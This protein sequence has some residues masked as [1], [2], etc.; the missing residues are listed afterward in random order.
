MTN[1]P[2]PP[3]IVYP[4]RVASAAGLPDRLAGVNGNEID[5]TITNHRSLPFRLFDLCGVAWRFLFGVA[6][7][8]VLLAIVANI[9]LL[10]L[11]ALGYLIES[12]GRVVR[13]GKVSAG[14]VGIDKARVFGGILLGVWLI[15]LPMRALSG[16]WQDAWL[17]DPSSPQ[18]RF[19]R[20][21]Q[22]ALV[23]LLLMHIATAT[24]CG[25]KLRHFLW[26]LLAPFLL[27]LRFVRGNRLSRWFLDATI[28]R[29]FP[30]LS[31][32]I[33]HAPPMR[34]WFVP[35]MIWQR[36]RGGSWLEFYRSCRDTTCEFGA[37]L[38]LWHYWW[39][40][41]KAFVGTLI[42][43]VVPTM[44]LASPSGLRPGPAA[45]IGLAGILVAVPVFFL[46]PFLQANFAIDGRLRGFFEP[47]RVYQN[48]SRSPI[49]HLMAL[50]ATAVLA[51]PLFLLKIEQIPGELFWMLSVVFVVFTWP[52]KI[53]TGWAVAR[54]YQHAGGKENETKPPKRFWLRWPVN[55]LSAAVAF[56]FA[57]ILFL[58]QYVSWSGSTSL[59]ENHAFL[60]PAPFWL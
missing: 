38:N 31:A 28:G 24:I 49:A 54:G 44:L 30:R 8:V 13:Q 33:Y 32:D 58:S 53:I 37:S 4:D 5:A 9:P 14:L 20:G 43:L 59:F 10:Q 45:L 16:F 52:A 34:D 55:V 18:T 39:F 56:V 12:M 7:L 3:P 17:I 47:R 42:W 40:G 2:T 60:L 41:L 57:V 51:L 15:V 19:L 26:P 36:S 46:L 29:W 25:G 22:F 1:V 27:A 50:V 6:S 21:L 35:A 48:F 11:A 23:P